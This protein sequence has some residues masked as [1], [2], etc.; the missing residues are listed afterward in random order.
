MAGRAGARLVPRFR[1][2]RGREIALGPGK[3]DLLAAIGRRG[4]LRS[5]AEDLSMSYMR[6][7]KLVRTM[8]ASFREPLVQLSRGGASGGGARLTKE[9]TEVLA[10]YRRIE[11]AGVAAAAAPWKR[12]RARLRA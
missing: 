8:N 4:G 9:G 5:A 3:A 6:A 7:W 11:R 2:L 1:V 12:L 10:L